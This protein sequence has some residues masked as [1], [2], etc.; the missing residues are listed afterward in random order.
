MVSL[1]TDKTIT[2]RS[3]QQTVS[4]SVFMYDNKQTAD[5]LPGNLIL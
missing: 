4:D 2:A 3:Q 1:V 5:F